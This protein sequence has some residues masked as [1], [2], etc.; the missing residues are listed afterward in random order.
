MWIQLSSKARKMRKIEFEDVREEEEGN[1][2]EVE[3]ENEDDN[4]Q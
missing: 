1:E 3:N 4:D 2:D